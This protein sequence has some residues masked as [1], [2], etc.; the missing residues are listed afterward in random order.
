MALRGFIETPVALLLA[1]SMAASVMAACAD[2]Q[3][4]PS[5]SP[6]P[7]ADPGAAPAEATPL[8]ERYLRADGAARLVLEVDAAANLAPRSRVTTS[9]VDALGLLLD[10]PGGIEVVE[11]SILPSRGEE[12][13]WTFEDLD[14]FAREHFGGDPDRDT[15]AIHVMIVDGRYATD[16][17]AGVVLGLAWGNRH[18]AIFAETIARACGRDPLLAALREELCE[19][20]EIATWLHE[21]GHVIGLV[22]NGLPMVEPHRDEDHGAHC[23]NRECLMYWTAKGSRLVDALGALL[24]DGGSP[25]F[26]FDEACVADLVAIRDR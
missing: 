21:I 22:D 20:V 26:R 7:D 2:E 4:R 6:R 24:L 15:V 23:T 12:H 8:V 10:K 19:D 18:L 1:A 13:R 17:D 16:S 3:D 14:A 9:V 25:R 5:N 11:D